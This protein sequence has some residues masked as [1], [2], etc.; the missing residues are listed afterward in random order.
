MS[1]NAPANPSEPRPETDTPPAA[2]NEVPESA[3]ERITPYQA[4]QRVSPWGFVFLLGL[5][6]LVTGWAWYKVEDDTGIV[7]QAWIFVSA[8]LTLAPLAWHAVDFFQSVASRRGGAFVAVLL[9]VGLGFVVMFT[10]SAL[11]VQYHDVIDEKASLDL[12]ESGRYTLGE[13]TRKIV[14]KLGEGTVYATYLS[15]G[16]RSR[17]SRALRDMAWEQLKVYGY[18]N[19]VVVRQFDDL[20]QKDAAETYLRSV[21]VLSTS[22]GETDDVIVL[23]YAEAGREVAQGKQKE[24]RVDEFTFAKSGAVDGAPRWLGERV[25]T[26]A[27]QELAF[28]KLKAYATGGHGEAGLA[29]QMRELRERLRSQN[30]EVVDKPLDLVSTP[31]VPE[32]CDL[33]LVL[34]AATPFQPQELDAVRS[35]LEKGRALFVTV[36]V[37]ESGR[38]RETGL[39]PLLD[40]Y[41]LAPRLNYVVIAPQVLDVGGGMGYAIN[42]TPELWAGEAEYADHR[43]VDGLRRGTGFRTVFLKST[44]VEFETEPKEG[45]EVDPVVWAPDPGVKG[46]KPF[47][48]RVTPDRRDFK[49]ADPSVDKQGTRLALVATAR[50]TNVGADAA[51]GAGRDSRVVFCGDTDAFIDAVVQQ[52]APNLDLF[53]GLAQWALRREDLVAVSD[54]TLDLE[55]ASVGDRERRMAFWWPLAIALSAL[56]AGAAVGWS[57]RR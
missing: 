52:N 11:N 35:W 46:A 48:A 34:G 7:T 23:T 53:G 1:E 17:T 30:V 4:A 19:R 38:R 49:V 10:G 24:I 8:L 25:I 40:A 6:G 31:S 56:L 42:M 15:R 3:L 47:A 37:E 39:E 22:S 50:R 14:A 33:L 9:T 54:K 55:I 12:T 16:E 43:A 45:L 5:A 41:G 26:S 44:F 29:D 2:S 21:G 18:T 32:D 57:R 13:E 20:R 27:I 51:G 36:D 28:V